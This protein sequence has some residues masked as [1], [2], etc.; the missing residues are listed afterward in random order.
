[1]N[2]LASSAIL[3]GSSHGESLLK[4]QSLQWLT[5]GGCSILSG[6]TGL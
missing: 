3:E 5:K 1:V 2:P 4:R 6:K